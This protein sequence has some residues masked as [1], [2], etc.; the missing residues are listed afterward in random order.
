[1]ETGKND[2]QPCGRHLYPLPGGAWGLWRWAAVRGAGFEAAAVLKL[3]APES[4]SA[5]VRFLNAE[6]RLMEARQKARSEVDSALDRLRAEGAWDD[7][8]RRRVLVDVLKRLKL[9]QLP[10]PG[11]SSGSLA[12]AL[13][14][15]RAAAA[16]ASAARSDYYI[17]FEEET[18]RTSCAIQDLLGDER[19]LE[20]VIWQN[21]RAFG[22]GLM[23]LAR[24]SS[25]GGSIASR[26]RANEALVANYLQRYC[27]KNDT[28]GFFGPVGWAQLGC[29]GAPIVADPGPNLTA[30][31]EVYFEAW[32]I[33]ALAEKIGEDASISPWI[34]P[35]RMPYVHLDGARVLVPNQPAAVISPKQALVLGLC[36]GMRTARDIARRIVAAG[37]P[38]FISEA[39]VYAVLKG[40]HNWRMLSWRLELPLD[41][42]PERRLRQLLDRI[43]SD[44]LRSASLTVLD[45]F[46]AARDRV[47]TAAGNLRV[48]DRS[49][50][51]LEETFTRVT[52]KTPSRNEGEMYA[53]RTLVYQDCRRDLEVTL[54]PE[55]L[56][57]LAD[58]L[59][60]LLASVRWLIHEV[61]LH[62]RK[63]LKVVH[64][65]L[66][67]RA[68]V[69]AVGATE[70]L[71]SAREL[72]LGK[73]NPLDPVF[74]A[75]Q[76]RWRDILSVPEDERRVR[77]SCRDLSSV[78]FQV[79]RAPDYSWASTRYHSPD[80]L[81]AASSLDAIRNGDFDFVL[82]EIHLAT[83]TL[84]SALFCHHHPS[85][86]ALQHA[87]D[88]DFPA[89]R[90][91][92]VAP[93]GS[94]GASS[95][96]FR[97]LRP[98][99]TFL[100]ELAEDS[101]VWD[102]S[103]VLGVGEFVVE[104]RGDA[105]IA[106]TRAGDIEFDVLK[107]LDGVLSA[108]VID[109]FKMF[110]SSR[111]RPRINF[112]KLVVCRESWTFS[113]DELEFSDCKTRAA[114]FLEAR[115]WTK[116]NVLPRFVFVSVPVERKPVFIDF[117]SPIYVDNFARI[118]RR[119]VAGGASHNA[120]TVTEMLPAVDQTWLPDRAGRRYASEFRMVVVDQARG[121]T[122]A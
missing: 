10:D 44:A 5:A 120:V 91:E 37:A 96:L 18:P 84:R 111:H 1:M 121:A 78:V 86:K 29:D 71:Q 21:H 36:D 119:A 19:F 89:T 100:L 73:A 28:I 109:A 25:A 99:N 101:L 56:D 113:P 114:R 61:A 92:V 64:S 23:S 41:S 93:K 13:E 55:L 75:F 24:K 33:D 90:Y 82:G 15:L 8:S 40:L 51:D 63:L 67:G 81:I 3:A 70:F 59:C 38:G 105:L 58:P 66:A 85:P 17:C 68:G 43:G 62:Y 31:T 53:G 117:D 4:S 32:C 57:E 95:R 52:G 49:M 69:V 39:D 34:A 26:D 45:E 20:A 27:V 54:G 72:V 106:H 116:A 122:D 60:I 80:I 83:N 35:R 108:V 87:I 48:L 22:L 97:S 115:R 103:R 65:D 104:P 107:D 112:D 110:L 76:E 46:E 74:R 11:R 77:Y 94:P 16:A 14:G 12:A 7:K 118:V 42:Y 2:K 88:C 79:F 6:D 102:R 30:T 98:A 47:A 50:T 9:N